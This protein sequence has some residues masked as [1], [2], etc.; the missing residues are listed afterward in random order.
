M[1]MRVTMAAIGV[2][3]LSVPSPTIAQSTPRSHRDLDWNAPRRWVH[4]DIVLNE[5][6]P[7]FERARLEWLSALS[8]GDSLLG[9]GRALFWQSRGETVNTYFTFYPFRAMAELD[10][11]VKMRQETDKVVGEA[12]GQR[13]DLGDAGIVSPHYS[14]I[15]RRSPD[16]DIAGPRAERLNELTAAV[17]R[18]DVHLPDLQRYDVVDSLWST[19]TSTLVK[20][21]YP[22]AC[23]AY[24]SVYGQ[25]EYMML[26]LAP[27]S[28]TYHGA[29]SI[30]S[31]LEREFGEREGRKLYA[32]FAA[33]FPIQRS[34]R[35]ERRADLSNLGQPA[36]R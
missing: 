22:L 34:Y 3:C 1:R 26:W 19:I 20:H 14:Q 21:D 31:F 4:V 23:R 36:K 25:G 7:V 33:V 13:Y 28:V 9:D 2:A 11:R 29:P 16:D 8:A 5:Q 10:E 6:V 30:E 12:A 17:G 24:G 32:D 18:L 15:W 35:V 27:D